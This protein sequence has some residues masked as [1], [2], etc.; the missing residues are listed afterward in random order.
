MKPLLAVGP[1][2]VRQRASGT[3]RLP[4]H[5]PHRP[6]P[7]EDEMAPRVPTPLDAERLALVVQQCSGRLTSI[8]RHRLNRRLCARLDPADV[9]QE[10]FL[11]ALQRLARGS[12]PSHLPL[13]LWLRLLTQQCVIRIHRQHLRAKKRCVAREHP[14]GPYDHPAASDSVSADRP[15]GEPPPSL[16]VLREQTEQLWAGVGQLRAIDRQVLKLRHFDGLTNEEVARRL[17]LSKAAA[18]KRYTTALRRLQRQM[19]CPPSAYF[20][21]VG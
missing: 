20:P 9:L 14:A 6:P 7:A 3:D 4:R 21:G 17:G 18:S 11:E 12:C 10:V 16:A 19:S 15:G 2:P 5:R 13:D 1:P 8:V